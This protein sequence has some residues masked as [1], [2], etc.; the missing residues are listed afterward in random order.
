MHL[1]FQRKEAQNEETLRRLK[2]TLRRELEGIERPRI[3]ATSV[4]LLS[5]EFWQ[6]TLLRWQI[7]K[8]SALKQ[9]L[10]CLEAACTAVSI[11]PHYHYSAG[12]VPSTLTALEEIDASAVETDVETF[13][14]PRYLFTG[15]HLALSR[16][17]ATRQFEILDTLPLDLGV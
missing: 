5:H 10:A 1:T 17:V 11:T 6:M 12:W 2:R 14:S 13:A 7:E 16:I 15:S 3:T 8:T 4:I 9:F